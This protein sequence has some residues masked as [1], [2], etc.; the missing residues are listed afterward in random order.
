MAKWLS[1][2]RSGGKRC[3]GGGTSSGTW[4]L[5]LLPLVLGRLWWFKRHWV[6]GGHAGADFAAQAR[7]HRPRLVV[8]V[9]KRSDPAAGFKVLPRRWLVERTFGWLMRHRAST[10]CPAFRTFQTRPNEL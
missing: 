4:G 10:D 2:A 7:A 1:R 6:N 5:A 8:E 3:L 9:V